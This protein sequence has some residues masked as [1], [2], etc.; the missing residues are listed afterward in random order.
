MG[1]DGS[2][3][4]KRPKAPGAVGGSTLSEDG[5]PGE[6]A[7]RQ[8]GCWDWLCDD[9]KATCQLKA[10][11]PPGAQLVPSSLPLALH[12]EENHTVQPTES[13]AQNSPGALEAIQAELQELPQDDGKNQ[14]LLLSYES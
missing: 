9:P 6:Q 12:S 5:G 8:P 13:L 2:E 4:S 3:G 11:F 7:A 1:V 14:I 10:L